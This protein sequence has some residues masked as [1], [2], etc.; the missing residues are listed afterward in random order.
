MKDKILCS[1]K[2]K[3]LFVII[4]D[5]PEIGAYAWKIDT[6]T[7]KIY[8]YADESEERYSELQ[9]TV[10]IHKELCREVW[11]VDETSWRECSEEELKLLKE[12]GL[13][14]ISKFLNPKR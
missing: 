10:E 9:G 4:P 6:E 7:G 3:F 14:R 2:G 5:K 12:I 13:K 8:E 1:R 11:G